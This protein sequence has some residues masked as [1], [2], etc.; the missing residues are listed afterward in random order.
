MHEIQRR[1]QTITT[2]ET[3]ATLPEAL[4]LL[5]QY[6]A[7]ARPVA[8]GTDLMMEL[9]RNQRPGVDVLIDLTRIAGLDEIAQTADGALQIGPLVTHNQVVASPLV[10][11]HALPLAQACWEVGSPQVRNRGTLAGNLVTASPAND[12]ITPL[13]ALDAQLT[14]A[15]AAGERSVPLRRFYTGV[16]RTVLQTGELLTRIT[17]P[18]RPGR[19][20]FVKLG[21]RRAQA[22]SVVHI[23]VWLQFDEAGRVAAADLALGSVAP[24]IISA[25]AAEARLIGRTLDAATIAEAARLAAQAPTPIDD[26][27]ADAAYRRETLA[28]MVRRALT[29]LADGREAEGWPDEPAM[30]WGRSDGRFPAEPALAAHHTPES[31][32]T[33]VVNGRTV[34]APWG[35]HQSLLD[36]LRD[37]G[38]LTGSKEG[39]AEGECGACTVHLD[40]LAVMSCLTPAPRAHGATITTIEGL[41]PDERTLHPLQ[42]AFIETGAVQCGYCIPGFLM[43]GAKLLEEHPHPTRAQILQAYAGNLCR[44]TGYYKIIEAVERVGATAAVPAPQE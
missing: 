28:V 7:R 36:W 26:V 13:W 21:N 40:G 32:I 39:C 1:G 2:Y 25:S 5:A 8:G 44:C 23:A 4:R 6:G 37:A 11:A 16:R 43:S 19:G 15:S 18:H 9:D 14:L 27:R 24:T 3:P 38:S 22:I 20:I 33:A 34:Q 17:I 12:A 41:A 10:R 31:L 30:L 35:P 29:A 42:Q